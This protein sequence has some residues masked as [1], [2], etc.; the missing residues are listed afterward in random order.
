MKP[1]MLPG[2]DEPAAA[3]AIALDP[4]GST[5]PHRKI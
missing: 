2:E 1:A 3:V 5:I 4:H